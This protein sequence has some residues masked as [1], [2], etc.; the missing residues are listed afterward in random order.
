MLSAARGIRLAATTT[1][2]D[3]DR[4]HA[5]LIPSPTRG[6]K[7]NAESWT[8]RSTPGAKSERSCHL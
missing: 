7:R 8:T 4:V 2:A 1:P 6:V 3:R 5:V